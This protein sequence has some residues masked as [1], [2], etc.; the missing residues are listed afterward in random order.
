MPPELQYLIKDLFEDITLFSNRTLASRYRKLPNG[1]YAVSVDVECE[2][3][4]SDSK[5]KTEKATVQDWIEIGAFAKPE[6]GKKY[7]KE[8]YRKREFLNAEK[9]TLEFEVDEVPDMA[10]IDPYYLMIDR[11]PEDN[12]K[13]AVLEEESNSSSAVAL[14][15]VSI[16]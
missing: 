11:V 15:E 5:G 1:K 9:A 8:L 4:K 6:A 16:K 3:L 10:G 2:K 13:R 12:L 14:K 7:G